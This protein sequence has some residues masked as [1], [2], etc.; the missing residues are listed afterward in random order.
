MIGL[1]VD[2]QTPADRSYMNILDNSVDAIQENYEEHLSMDSADAQ[3]HHSSASRGDS[4][5]HFKSMI[6]GFGQDPLDPRMTMDLGA[7]KQK[8]GSLLQNAN[9]ISSILPSSRNDSSFHIPSKKSTKKIPKNK[10]KKMM[11]SVNLPKKDYSLSRQDS[12]RRPTRDKRDSMQ[13]IADMLSRN[14]NSM[15]RVDEEKE[16][17]DERKVIKSSFDLSAQTIRQREPDPHEPASSVTTSKQ[18]KH[19]LEMALVA[20]QNAQRV[21][22]LCEKADAV[23]TSFQ[24]RVVRAAWAD[25]AERNLGYVR[26]EQVLTRLRKRARRK[27]FRRVHRWLVKRKWSLEKMRRMALNRE[28]LKFRKTLISLKY[29][30][31]SKRIVLE[32][33]VAIQ[34]VIKNRADQHLRHFFAVSRSIPRPVHK[35]VI[36]EQVSRESNQTRSLSKKRSTSNIFDNSLDSHKVPSGLGVSNGNQSKDDFLNHQSNFNTFFN[37]EDGAKTGQHDSEAAAQSRGKQSQKA[38]DDEKSQKSESKVFGL[39]DKGQKQLFGN[40]SLQDT[41]G[42][43]GQKQSKFYVSPNFNEKSDSNKGPESGDESSHDKPPGTEHIT[44]DQADSE[45]LPPN[46]SIFRRRN[47]FTNNFSE[48]SETSNRASISNKHKSSNSEL[49][50]VNSNSQVNNRYSEDNLAGSDDD[51]ISAPPPRINRINSRFSD[52]DDSQHSEPGSR[53]DR[54]LFVNEPKDAEKIQQFANKF[55][56]LNQF[57]KPTMMSNMMS[58]P[59]RPPSQARPT[60]RQTN[61]LPLLKSPTYARKPKPANSRKSKSDSKTSRVKS[62]VNQYVSQKRQA[63]GHQ[64]PMKLSALIGKRRRTRVPQSTREGQS[65]MEPSFEAS[66]FTPSHMSLI[67]TQTNQNNLAFKD[68]MK[69]VVK[70]LLDHVQARKRKH[71]PAQAAWGVD[72]RVE[73][74]GKFLKVIGLFE[75]YL[76]TLRKSGN[77]SQDLISLKS[78]I[79]KMSGSLKTLLNQEQA[80]LRRKLQQFKMDSIEKF[81]IFIYRKLELENV[82]SPNLPISG[83]IFHF[84][85]SETSSQIPFTNHN[86]PSQNSSSLFLLSQT[87]NF[88]QNRHMQSNHNSPRLPNVLKN[89]QSHHPS[90]RPSGDTLLRRRFAK[91][92]SYSN[93]N[94]QFFDKRGSPPFKEISTQY[95]H[96]ESL[97]INN[98]LTNKI[99]TFRNPGYSLTNFCALLNIKL[100]FKIKKTYEVFFDLARRLP[101]R[102][103]VFVS[104]ISKRILRMFFR[105]IRKNMDFKLEIALRLLRMNRLQRVHSRRPPSNPRS[106]RFGGARRVSP[107]WQTTG[108]MN[109]PGRYRKR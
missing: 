29:Y 60:K 90:S 48:K 58:R 84:G 14:K 69:K 33:F 91:Q 97:V 79:S 89:V 100:R 44:D 68:N 52:N 108:H 42:T 98:H 25:L 70:A 23:L 59:R 61:T 93:S 51:S 78:N 13:K 26:L 19:S 16:W 17:Q 95:I 87:R 9:D 71:Y 10:M 77:Q 41:F 36:S 39:Y 30:F 99:R 21:R 53:K 22:L 40:A 37:P 32:K 66:G 12:D 72:D 38:N 81:L 62:Y 7:L 4:P 82:Y 106:G 5:D 56:S 11:M 1:D 76:D 63:A 46:D 74:I 94:N 55:S 109:M 28:K 31:Y 102:R 3:V 107:S 54:K 57:W 80:T 65:T 105:L 27:W 47:D 50:R 6:G 24:R 49:L 8:K 67:S 85:T 73:F 96:T 101:P 35:S 104:G 83:S 88:G 86:Y 15:T 103:R 18:S 45:T 2:R 92:K 43:T 75:V 34:R 64:S 20:E